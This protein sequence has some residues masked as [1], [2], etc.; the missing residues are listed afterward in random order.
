MKKILSFLFVFI[1]L[2]TGCNNEVKHVE[3]VSHEIMGN[4]RIEIPENCSAI[5]KAIFEST[6]YV[7][8]TVVNSNMKK[9][10]EFISFEFSSDVLLSNEDK[11]LMMDLFK[12]Y[13][14]EI[15]EGLRKGLS[16]IERG[17]TIG[18]G[19]I[20]NT[21]LED[22]DLTIPVKIYYGKNYYNYCCD[23]K[24]YNDEYVMF[25]TEYLSRT[26]YIQ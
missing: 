12:V 17:V 20:K 26:W 6:D 24:M 23:F 11:A 9:K 10:P 16:E 13:N 1:L 18:Y 15:T 3:D 2:F 14:V 19:S 8:N 21:Q 22:C 5:T 4:V 7:L 25:R